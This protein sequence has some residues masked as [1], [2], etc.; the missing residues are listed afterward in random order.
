MDTW[1]A[2]KGN[3]RAKLQVLNA[4]NGFK[5]YSVT[6]IYYPRTIGIKFVQFDFLSKISHDEIFKKLLKILKL[7]TEM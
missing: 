7:L 6:E 1:S 5:G 3:K 2:F 4:R